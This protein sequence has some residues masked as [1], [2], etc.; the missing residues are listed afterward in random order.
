MTLSLSR[1]AYLFRSRDKRLQSSVS[2]THRS[3]LERA[4]LAPWDRALGGSAEQKGAVGDTLN[5]SERVWSIGSEI[6]YLCDLA[7]HTKVLEVSK[8]IVIIIVVSGLHTRTPAHPHP[9][10]Q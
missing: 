4:G 6:I 9:C 8:Q 2:A 7:P 10:T 1:V 3:R 5:R